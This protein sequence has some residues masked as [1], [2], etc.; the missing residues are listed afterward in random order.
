MP[1]A[2]KARSLAIYMLVMWAGCVPSQQALFAP[3]RAQAHERL[4][5]DLRW[6]PDSSQGSEEV[7]K[8]LQAPLT[9]ESATR[10]ALLNNEALQATFEELGVRGATLAQ[11][12]APHNPELEAE[13][14]YPLDGDHDPHL[15]LH[16]SQSLS[17]L[18]GLP[19]R[20]GVARAELDAARWRAV[21]AAVNLAAE[22]RMAFYRALAASQILAMQRIIAEAAATSLELASRLH[23]AGNITDLALAQEQALSA[24]AR[25]DLA[26]A[27]TA[28]RAT[29][30]RLNATLGLWGEQ[31]SWTLAGTIEEVPP[32]PV[33]ALADL[34][35]DAVARS[36]ALEELRAAGE[37]AARAVGLARITSWMPEIEVGVSGKREGESWQL[38]PALALSIPI[39]D[40]GQ[41]AR[42]GAWA[43]LRQ[44]QHQYRAQ[45]I[46][47]RSTARAL[48]QRYEA[49][50][51]RALHLRDVV[52]PLRA[53]I[54]EETVLQYNAMNASP[55]ELLVARQQEIQASRQLMESMRDAWIAWVAIEQLR[56]GGSPENGEA[57]ASNAPGPSHNQNRDH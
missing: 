6:R 16:V 28:A 4:G 44:V 50:R 25:L 2:L 46:E 37:A 21:A 13:I 8:L 14:L 56:A 39:F 23:A 55:F 18:V 24:Q 32:A 29:H 7:A 34:E 22:A 26:D 1:C 51:T 41:G 47:I 52:L 33:P 30:E 53:R 3:V 43:R 15:E 38:G 27:E 36:L 54:L 12:T 45:A 5:Q 10:I 49:A 19:A 42:A 40:M 48:G 17:S 11:A 57:P 9:A 35:A 31:T 20:R